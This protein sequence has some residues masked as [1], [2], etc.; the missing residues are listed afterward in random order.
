[1]KF[2]DYS[3]K[4]GIL[5]ITLSSWA[6][7]CSLVGKLKVWPDYKKYV[8]RG[9]RCD[10]LKL[11]SSFD[12]AFKG[13]KNERKRLLDEYLNRLRDLG[14]KLPAINEAETEVK[15]WAIVQH[16]KLSPTPLLDW[17][18]SPFVAGFF[19]FAKKAEED[20]TEYRVVYGLRK[21]LR[22]LMQ[23]KKKGKKRIGKKRFVEIPDVK[24]MDNP[25]LKAQNALFTKALDGRDIQ[26]IVRKFAAKRPQ[27]VILIEIKIPD[28]ERDECLK[29]LNDSGINH[30]TLF[31]DDYGS[32]KFCNLKLEIDN[33]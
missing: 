9:Q 23:I 26:N 32:A 30:V 22:R 20:Q 1:M 11:L 25:R 3:T 33:Y 16:Y 7:F 27:E 18:G 2:T 5:T 21:G 8:W 12:R 17:T 14:S 13:D 10:N 24:G 28:R 15:L 29:S 31:P 6:D 4:D 19:A